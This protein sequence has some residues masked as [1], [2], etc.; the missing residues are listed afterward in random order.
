MVPGAKPVEEDGAASVAE[1]E[2]VALV[3]RERSEKRAMMA[4]APAKADES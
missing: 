1:A 2:A 4:D 3:K